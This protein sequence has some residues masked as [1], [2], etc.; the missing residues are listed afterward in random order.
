VSEVKPLID[1][2]KELKKL[3]EK[4]EAENKLLNK[5][6]ELK[7][8]KLSVNPVDLVDNNMLV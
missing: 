1:Q 3:F 5:V 4:S 8:L 7:Q 6:E 2:Y